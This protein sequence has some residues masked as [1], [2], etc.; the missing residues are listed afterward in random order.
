MLQDA[1]NLYSEWREK[2]NY[3]AGR[4]IEVRKQ[5]IYKFGGNRY[6]S[7]REKWFLRNL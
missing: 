5:F 7:Q 6:S 2:E 4:F 3:S 1:V